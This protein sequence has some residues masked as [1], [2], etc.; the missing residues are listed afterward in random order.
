MSDDNSRLVYSTD[1]NVPRKK[2]KTFNDTVTG[3]PPAEQ[4]V[5]I[6]LD[7]KGRGGKSVTLVEGIQ[8]PREEMKTFLKQLKAKLGT[9]GAVKDSSI[10]IQGEHCDKIITILEKLG[11]RPRR[12][13]G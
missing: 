13:G 4:K 3:L 8:M 10:E 2:Q 1:R 12:S 5:I 6:R 11:Y 9:G 7:R